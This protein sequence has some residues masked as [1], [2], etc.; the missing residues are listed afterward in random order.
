[1]KVKEESQAATR[2]SYTKTGNNSNNSLLG[3]PSKLY[4][5]PARAPLMYEYKIECFFGFGAL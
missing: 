4:S 2:Q 1:M 5:A 3:E